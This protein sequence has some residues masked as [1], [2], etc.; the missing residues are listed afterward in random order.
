MPTDGEDVTVLGSHA[1]GWPGGLECED[2]ESGVEYPGEDHA[3]SVSKKLTSM[4]NEGDLIVPMTEEAVL[5]TAC[6]IRDSDAKG[7]SM[8]S[9]L[10][11]TDRMT[12]RSYLDY[13]GLNPKW[14]LQGIENPV[15]KAPYSVK[16]KGVSFNGENVLGN[17]QPFLQRIQTLTGRKLGYLLK[18]ERLVGDHYEVNGINAGSTDPIELFDPIKQTWSGDKITQYDKVEDLGL[19]RE[20]AKVA[21]CTVS[22]LGINWAGWCVEIM[23]PPFRVVEAHA[24]LGWDD[25]ETYWEALGAYTHVTLVN[26]LCRYS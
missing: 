8:S 23:G 15:L 1:A 11:C 16:N 2:L 3:I 22:A 21:V 10:A 24:R 7:L 20:L 25:N 14:S 19:V 4:V 17:V 12:Q 5:V 6:A 26:T 18:E 9:A 13:V